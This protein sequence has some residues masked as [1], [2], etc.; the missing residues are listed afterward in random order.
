MGLLQ[1]F[2]TL[3]LAPLVTPVEKGQSANYPLRTSLH[4]SHQGMCS[5]P[6]REREMGGREGGR[7]KREE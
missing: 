1:V 7:E 4:Y 5:Y 3:H 2:P 6:D